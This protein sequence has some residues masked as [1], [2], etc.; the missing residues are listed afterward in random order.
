MSKPFVVSWSPT[1][2]ARTDTSLFMR[3]W[4][5][6]TATDSETEKKI[7]RD[8]D[9]LKLWYDVPFCIN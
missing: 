3:Q 1:S 4:E 9:F 5:A 2:R 8:Q 6:V 7:V